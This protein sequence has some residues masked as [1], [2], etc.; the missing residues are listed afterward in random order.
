VPETVRNAWIESTYN[1]R[2]TPSIPNPKDYGDNTPQ[3]TPTM[4]TE[5]YVAK[6]KEEIQAIIEKYYCSG[7]ADNIGDVEKSLLDQIMEEINK[8]EW[9]AHEH[10]TIAEYDLKNSRIFSILG[11]L[12]THRTGT[13]ITADDKTQDNSAPIYTYSVLNAADPL[14][15]EGGI[16]LNIAGYGI[17]IKLSWQNTGVH[18]FGKSGENSEIT[19][20]LRIDFSEGEIGFET[21]TS[22]EKDNKTS[23]TYESYNINFIVPGGAAI[24]IL[25][26]PQLAAYLASLL[27]SGGVPVPAG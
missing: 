16:R 10:T 21:T 8:R 19:G 23:T 3:Y 24:A 27:Q 5:E 11:K 20:G 15:S 6:K 1:N 7:E 9:K 22:T 17:D 12:I 2:G 14:S 18:L 13:K 26:S 25:G 4:T